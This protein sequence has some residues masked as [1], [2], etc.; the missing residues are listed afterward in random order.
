MPSNIY[1]INEPLKIIWGIDVE[2]IVA[3]FIVSIVLLLLSTIS[4][5]FLY[6]SFIFFFVSISVM[7]SLKAGKARGASWRTLYKLGLPIP[8]LIP[9]PKIQ[10]HFTLFQAKKTV[11]KQKNEKATIRKVYTGL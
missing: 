4:D 10:P 8:G 7:K 6:A 2:D 9:H 5:K 1:K 11:K 3:S